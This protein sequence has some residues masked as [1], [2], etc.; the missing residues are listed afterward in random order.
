MDDERVAEMEHGL[1]AEPEL[2]DGRTVGRLDALTEGE[3][4]ALILG[5]EHPVVDYEES[6]TAQ[7]RVVGVRPA[8]RL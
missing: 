1:L 6:G 4:A 8:Y 7:Q 5:T 3:N 2:P